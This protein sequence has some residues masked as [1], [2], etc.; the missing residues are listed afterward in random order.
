MKHNRVFPL[1]IRHNPEGLIPQL[2]RVNVVSLMK[3][4]L[5]LLDR[6]F[7]LLALAVSVVFEVA[8]IAH[9]STREIRG[10]HANVVAFYDFAHVPDLKH[11]FPP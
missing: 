4:F 6:P 1:R 8:F 10:F 9:V 3:N 7:L 2:Y 5:Q 11:R